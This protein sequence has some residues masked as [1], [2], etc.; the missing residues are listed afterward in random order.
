MVSR[1]CPC[2][3]LKGHRKNNFISRMN[4]ERDQNVFQFLE[5]SKKIRLNISCNFN[6]SKSFLLLKILCV[7]TLAKSFTIFLLNFH[8]FIKIGKWSG[9][10]N[11]L[12][13]NTFYNLIHNFLDGNFLITKIVFSRLTIHVAI[14]LTAFW[15]DNKLN[16]CY[17]K[18]RWKTWDIKNRR[19]QL[20]WASVPT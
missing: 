13:L 19:S 10:L 1:F 5:I 3:H 20:F 8:Q 2:L 16:I 9:S 17:I 14:C 12:L 6:S 18:S 15:W 11:V 4:T 7:G